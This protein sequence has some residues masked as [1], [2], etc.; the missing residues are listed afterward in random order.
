[1][2]RKKIITRICAAL[3]VVTMGVSMVSGTKVLAAEE[4]L[5][6]PSVDSSDE[7]A[8]QNEI[9]DK[10]DAVTEENSDD[11]VLERE[12]ISADG[13]AEEVEESV[14]DSTKPLI[15]YLYVEKPNLSVGEKQKIVVSVAENTEVNGVSLIYQKEE[16]SE[17]LETYS[18]NEADGANEFDIL[19]PNESDM[20]T[21]YIQGVKIYNG[22]E[23]IVYN[24][25]EIGID[26][27]FGVE[28][29]C[30]TEPDAIVENADN[31]TAVSDEAGISVMSL[32]DEGNIEDNTEVEESVNKEIN[33]E[34]DI[35]VYSENTEKTA[36][37]YVIV[38]DPGHG[39]YDGGANG[40][41]VNE[42]DLT[43]KIAKYCKKYLE[44]QGNAKVYMTRNDDTYVSL[45]GRVDYAASVNA[46]LFVS[47]HLNSG[48]GYGAE[49][50]YPN[51]NYRS[52]IGS[53]GK[54][55]AQSVQDELIALGIYSR[56]IKIRNSQDSKYP[57]GSTQDYYAVIQRSKRAGFP[58]I[59]IEH[60]F[61]DNSNDFSAYLNSEEK[62][63][64]LGK[65]DA[66]GILKYIKTGKGEWKEDTN[67]WKYQYVLGGYAVDKWE[68]IDGFWY[69][70][71]KNGYRKTGFV[72]LGSVTYYFNDEGKMSIGWEKINNNYYYF[73]SS[74]A[75]QIGWVKPYDTW[76]YVN[77]E[78]VM[79]TGWLKLTEGTYY[80]DE[81]GA[82]VEGW[83]WIDG[84]CYYFKS[85]GS[86]A[87]D[88]WIG[89]SYVDKDGVWI[90]GKTK[91]Q[92][93]WIQV[94]NEK[95]YRH[96]DGSYTRSNWEKIDGKWYF[97]DQN[98]WLKRS[99]WVKPYDTWYYVD[100]EGVMQ[101]GWLKLT[102]GTYYL[103]ESGALVEGWRVIDGTMCYFRS[104]GS[105][106][107]KGVT[108]IMG[109]SGLGTTKNTVVDKL[110]KMYLKSG[111]IYPAYYSQYGGAAT[112]REFCEIIYEEATDENVKPEVVF[113]QAMKE[114]GYL[115]FGRD[116]QIEQFNF[117][118]LGATG[119]GVH[120]NS[121]ANIREGIRAQVQHLKAYASKDSLNHDCVDV[122]F[123]YVNRGSAPYVEWLGIKE[124][125]NKAGWAASSEYGI[126]LVEKYISPMYKL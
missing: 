56:G 19:F 87:R 100:S 23:E 64:R 65:A 57:D 106:R 111:R 112:I 6:A 40:N 48:G 41:G 107:C 21:Y 115:Q 97:F 93:K 16:T 98:G 110:E 61:I 50:Y 29:Y 38:L 95:W 20:G 46:N 4:L 54:T 13:V 82:L 124:N 84:K 80:L 67:G 55:L 60:A 104:G 2:K 26:A 45:A 101:T 11:S 68:K 69:F 120:G 118:G 79:Q 94:G 108:T 42:K 103:D 1:M 32:D 119:N 88:T 75:M 35:A 33:S 31:S 117:A 7:I 114:T 96:A 86:M 51:S 89:D 8:Q 70:F 71:D 5:T 81:S 99:C 105:L 22:S 18:V 73:S 53:E 39:G 74:G 72:E 63:D 28:E 62:L 85:G 17:I 52:D 125:P 34:N 90:E 10:A 126:D 59:I 77:S 109:T 47:I 102:E 44:Q 3:M 121:F 76:Y 9:E 83:R 91:N 37:P 30:E 123:G 24:F 14:N 113:G 92:A 12:N 49:V 15:Q 36:K 116:V 122:R 25:K 27:K 58:G 43:L 78:G 66:N